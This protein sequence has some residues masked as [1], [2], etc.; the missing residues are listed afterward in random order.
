MTHKKPIHEKDLS[1][2]VRQQRLKKVLWWVAGAHLAILV[3]SSIGLP[4]FKK[5]PFDL[6][7]AVQ[8]DLIAATAELSAAPNKTNTPEPFVPKAKPEPEPPK[9]APVQKQAVTKLD[10]LKKPEPPPE[11]KSEPKPEPVKKPDDKPKLE[12]AKEQEKPKPV[13]KPK[14][15]P[16]KKEPP[17]KDPQKQQ[18]D[19]NSLLTNLLGD[20][21]SDAK[22]KGNPIDAPVDEKVKT[23]GKA[24]VTSDVLALSEM[25]ALKYQLAECWN[26]PA[27]ALDA[28]NLIVDIRVEVNRDRTVRTA[29]IVDRGRYSRD[30]FFRAAA[31][32]ARRAVFNPRCTPLALP[33]DKYDIWKTILIRFNPKDMFGG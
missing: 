22:P 4:Q 16:P 28:E 13:P 23:P 11:P 5:E 7:Q 26:V 29:E 1:Q 2:L 25:D 3:I 18:M 8:V 19:M 27:G 12:K 9:P 17:K 30:S 31:D 10:A 32:S 24:P 6:S 21:A 14:K 20:E 15:E 33:P